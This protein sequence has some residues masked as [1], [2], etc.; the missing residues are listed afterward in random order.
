MKGRIMEIIAVFILAGILLMNVRMPLA[1]AASQTSINA[2]I[3]KGLVYL[4]NTQDPDGSWNE[5]FAYSIANTAMAVLAFENQGHYSWN[6]SDPYSTVVQK[7]LNYL[8]ANGENITISNKTWGNP[9]T[10]GDGIG[11]Y[12][13]LDGH[14][15]STYETSMALMAIVGS[16]APTN[17]TSAGPLGVRTYHAIVQDIVDYLAYGQNDVSTGSYRGGWG[18]Y[19]N[20]GTS[21]NSNTAWP[22]LALMAAKLWGINAPAF[23][24]TELN[25]WVLNC[26]DLIGDSTSNPPTTS[27]GYGSFGYS[28]RDSLYG[29]V[30]EAASGI[31][32]LTYIGEPTSNSSIIA[33]EGYIN[34]LWNVSF[35]GGWDVNIGNLYAMYGVMK[36]CREATPT[37]IQYI[38]NYDGTPG[39]EWYNGTDEYAD[40]LVGNQSADG[41][42]VNWVPWAESDAY[43][44]ALSTALGVLILEFVPVRV[45]YSLTVTVEDATN[46]NPIVGAAVQAVGPETD[47]GNT[48]SN[49]QI[50]FLSVQAGSYQVNASAS[51]YSPSG[52][53][54]SLTS[55]TA[56][57]IK[58]SP[59]TVTPPP[60]PKPVGGKIE[61]VN[62]PAV[63]LA[64]VEDYAKYW[65][66]LLAV[67]AL[68][69]LIIFKRRRT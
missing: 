29:G 14:M 13:T 34:A 67:G 9:D 15:V 69:T 46:N 43:S 2:A 30:V 36:A 50:T 28:A 16:N 52:T 11:V 60:P 4:N 63:L 23:V 59:T 19:E 65:V 27:G 56:V 64:A 21:D 35:A 25:Y 31:V 32:Q 55:S 20:Y 37:P 12:W 33:A 45:T 49:G 54:V 48:G 5:T 40:A 6:V 1:N 17:V 61:P 47:S 58:L 22:V 42:W 26:Q 38:A 24:A 68:A 41:S 62:T 66:A 57:T 18:Y 7:G 3:T 53:T 51:G 44:T 10:S 39:V 8:F